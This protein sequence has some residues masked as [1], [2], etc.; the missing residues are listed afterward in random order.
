MKD[1][2]DYIHT[3]AFVSFLLNRYLRYLSL[4]AEKK[5]LLLKWKEDKV[6]M[7]RA[8][9]EVL[10]RSVGVGINGQNRVIRDDDNDSDS[11]FMEQALHD[12]ELQS[13]KRLKVSQW[14]EN[15]QKEIEKKQVMGAT[16]KYSLYVLYIVF[17]MTF[18]TF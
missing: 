14:K 17:C 7:E 5:R 18:T 1:N 2:A 13:E 9:A 11:R 15:K 12:I 8:A 3:T 16:D 4:N 10:A 6:N